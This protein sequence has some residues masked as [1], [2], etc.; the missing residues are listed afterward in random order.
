MR[1]AGGGREGDNESTEM[2]CALDHQA[3]NPGKG[4]PSPRIQGKLNH[5]T[6]GRAYLGGPTGEIAGVVVGK[7]FPSSALWG[8]NGV[9]NRE[10]TL[11][12]LNE[13]SFGTAR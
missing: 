10:I 4:L 11:K 7:G 6:T 3:G 2:P 5:G 9:Q 8:L 12:F 13:G 1:L